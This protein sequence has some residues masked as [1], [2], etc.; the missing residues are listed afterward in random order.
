MA[1]ERLAYPTMSTDQAFLL[2]LKSSQPFS[3]SFILTE[4]IKSCIRS[5]H[6]QSLD[7]LLYNY[8]ET[9]ISYMY[10][11]FSFAVGCYQLQTVQKFVALI[12]PAYTNYKTL[13]K[14]LEYVIR[15]DN[16][17]EIVKMYQYLLSPECM[18]K[19]SELDQ[20]PFQNLAE[21]TCRR[22]SS[23]SPHMFQ[24]FQLLMSVMNQEQ[25]Y[26]AVELFLQRND[27]L[28]KFGLGS[29]QRGCLISEK[30]RLRCIDLLHFKCPFESVNV[31]RLLDDDGKR[32]CIQALMVEIQRAH[33]Y[34]DNVKDNVASRICLDVVEYCVMSYL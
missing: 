13:Y 1:D 28:S 34:Y 4:A 11:L 23:R 14:A 3:S 6:Q 17:E 9:F 19:F 20:L 24:C 31:S 21:F 25:V 7:W 26:R 30:D 10:D 2:K 29:T 5:N 33:E 8:R 15:L 32:I 16:S 27:I 12:H 22:A 18:L